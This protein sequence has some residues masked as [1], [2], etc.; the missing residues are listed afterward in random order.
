MCILNA[1]PFG[2][3]CSLSDCATAS[4]SDP[5]DGLCLLA[6]S[7]HGISGGVGLTGDGSR[8]GCEEGGSDGD[9]TDGN[10]TEERDDV[11]DDITS[12]ESMLGEDDTCDDVLGDLPPTGSR[13]FMPGKPGNGGLGLLTWVSTGLDGAELDRKAGLSGVAGLD[14]G[15]GLF[16]PTLSVSMP[17]SAASLYTA[18]ITSPITHNRDSKFMIFPPR[19]FNNERCLI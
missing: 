5:T 10:D 13:G 18:T 7:L 17:F 11:R 6:D 15:E 4:D 2:F 9:D 14:A 12:K 19:I 16:F 3:S 8:D 1:D